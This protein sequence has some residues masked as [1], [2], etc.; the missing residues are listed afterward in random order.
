ML[1]STS[2]N[3]ADLVQ[4]SSASRNAPASSV[5]LANPNKEDV[6]RVTVTGGKSAV[7][8]PKPDQVLRKKVHFDH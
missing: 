5:T 7:L 4:T 8:I 3:K 6:Q 1:P 2:D